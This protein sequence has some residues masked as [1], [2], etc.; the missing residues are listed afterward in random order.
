MMTSSVLT[1]QLAQ[2]L[3][4]YMIVAGLSGLVAPQRWRAMIEEMERSPGLIMLAGMIAFAIGVALVLVHTI[5]TDPLAVIVTL[6]GWS[7]LIKGALLIAVPGP[8]MRMGRG[9]L[10]LTRIWS[11]VVIV[12]GL[13]LGLAGLTGRAGFI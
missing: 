12:L 6:I 2:A 1:L 11:I 10:G 3:G 4:L 7:A 8:L 9:I 13:A 5:L